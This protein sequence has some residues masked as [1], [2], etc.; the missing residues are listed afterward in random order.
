MVNPG[1]GFVLIIIL[2]QTLL[3]LRQL[4]FAFHLFAH[5][6]PQHGIGLLLTNLAIPVPIEHHE[7]LVGL[8]PRNQIELVYCFVQEGDELGFC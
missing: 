1:I 7:S 5:H 4:I 2:H 8:H 6:I 3:H